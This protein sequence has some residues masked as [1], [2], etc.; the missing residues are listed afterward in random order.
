MR[1]DYNK[2]Q[3]YLVCIILVYLFIVIISNPRDLN[4]AM[5]LMKDGLSSYSIH[6]P[7]QNYKLS[8]EH[9]QNLVDEIVFSV[10]I[11]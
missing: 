2:R 3:I 5:V 9:V 4:L 10:C 7:Y 6:K 11:P 8:K 1:R